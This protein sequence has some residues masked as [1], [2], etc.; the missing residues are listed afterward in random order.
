[1]NRTDLLTTIEDILEV[2][3]G[4]VSPDSSLEALDWDS[5]ANISFIAEL[6]LRFGL[7]VDPQSLSEAATVEQLLELIPA[8]R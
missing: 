1:M 7:R 2:P 6:D 3:H 5:L 4:S 8:S